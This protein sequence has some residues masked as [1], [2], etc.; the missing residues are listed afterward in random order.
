MLVKEIDTSDTDHETPDPEHGFGL[1]STEDEEKLER[2]LHERLQGASVMPE[3]HGM[4]TA[5]V[6]GPYLL[7]L[8]WIVQTAFNVPHLRANGSVYIPEFNWVARKIEELIGRII[9][10]F[11]Q[12][13]KMFRLLVDRPKLKE[14]DSSPNPRSWCLGFVEAMAYYREDWKP[15]LSTAFPVVAPIVMTAEPDGWGERENLNPFKQMP[16]SEVCERVKKATGTINA[17]W[18]SYDER[19]GP[20]QASVVPGRNQPCP[21]GSRQKF[22]RCCGQLG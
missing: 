21:C 4:L 15:L 18:S 9:R 11:E 20:L 6:V 2:I 8:D 13:P 3:M 19:R 17:F 14:G 1:L 16:T 7:P 10:V 22:K 5:S 12:D